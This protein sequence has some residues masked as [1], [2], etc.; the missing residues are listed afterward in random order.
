MK[1][2]IIIGLMILTATFFL[3]ILGM[4]RQDESNSHKYDLQDCLNQ[5]PD[6]DGFDSFDYCWNKIN[7]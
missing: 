3:G 1:D 7:P 2:Y 6:Q 4:I 5:N